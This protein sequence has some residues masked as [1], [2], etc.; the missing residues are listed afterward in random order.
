MSKTKFCPFSANN[1]GINKIFAELTLIMVCFGINARP[2]FVDFHHINVYP[3]MPHKHKLGRSSIY[4][5]LLKFS[6]A[7]NFDANA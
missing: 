1:E 7:C 4:F 2:I 5:F 3:Q 6:N